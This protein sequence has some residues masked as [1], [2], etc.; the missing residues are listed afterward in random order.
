MVMREVLRVV[1]RAIL[2]MGFE[3]VHGPNGPVRP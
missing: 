1:L 2:S 3:L